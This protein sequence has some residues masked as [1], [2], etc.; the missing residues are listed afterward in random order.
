MF[1]LTSIIMISCF[2]LIFIGKFLPYIW[3]IF[4]DNQLSI[5][6]T[7]LETIHEKLL[8]LN[9]V[10]P[11]TIKMNWIY[12]IGIILNAMEVILQPVR[13]MNMKQNII[14]HEMVTLLSINI[15]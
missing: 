1:E 5:V 13:V 7:K 3:R 2:E 14:I 10:G 15:L 8:R 6:L 12:I 4:F 9:V 11:I